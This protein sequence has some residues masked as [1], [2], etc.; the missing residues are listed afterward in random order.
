MAKL[1]VCSHANAMMSSR[2]VEAATYREWPARMLCADQHPSHRSIA[3]FRQ[4]LSEL[5]VQTHRLCKRPRL[6]GPG[7]LAVNGTNRHQPARQRLAAQGDELRV[8]DHE[9][10]RVGGEIAAL[11]QNVDALRMAGTT[12]DRLAY[13]IGCPITWLP[14]STASSA[15]HARQ[16]A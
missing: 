9:G 1:L 7:T 15:R 6:V 5:L 4:A 12:A 11:R 10:G 13:F 3:R 16:W 14:P 2:S 8:D